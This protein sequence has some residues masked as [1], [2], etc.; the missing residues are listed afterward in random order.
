MVLGWAGWPGQSPD[1]VKQVNCDC[2]LLASKFLKHARNYNVNNVILLRARLF[3]VKPVPVKYH[4][5]SN[6]SFFP[7]TLSVDVLGSEC[8]SQVSKPRRQC[9][10]TW[11]FSQVEV[12]CSVLYPSRR[13]GL[14]RDGS[15][16][17]LIQGS[18]PETIH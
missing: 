15:L 12:A 1:R 3:R 11:R 14:E 2:R 5:V 8:A 10:Q 9:I 13:S 7:K 4:V 17:S 6:S 16:A 18:S